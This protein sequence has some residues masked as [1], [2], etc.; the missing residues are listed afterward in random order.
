MRTRKMNLRYAPAALAA[1]MGGLGNLVGGPD[2]S[3]PSKSHHKRT[4]RRDDRSAGVSAQR[5]RAAQ[6]KRDRRGAR[7][8]HEQ[9]QGGWR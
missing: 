6:D 4:P 8:L 9:A 1:I 2:P 3:R 7:R 5:V